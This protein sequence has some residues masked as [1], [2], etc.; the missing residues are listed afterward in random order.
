MM[1]AL[2]RGEKK[3]EGELLRKQIESYASMEK[4]QHKQRADKAKDE[5]K[6]YI[7]QHQR[8]KK[9]EQELEKES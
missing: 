1:K 9:I 3:Q 2:V 5:I 6:S 8:L 4:S 7:A